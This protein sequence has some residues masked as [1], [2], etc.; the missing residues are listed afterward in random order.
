MAH[1]LATPRHASGNCTDKPADRVNL[2]AVIILE[3][4]AGQ[5]FQRFNLEPRLG[6]NGAVIIDCDLRL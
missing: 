1:H 6:K 2:V 5:D 4:L 3:K